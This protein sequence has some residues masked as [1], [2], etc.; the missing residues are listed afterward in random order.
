M[1]QLQAKIIRDLH[2][3]AS[4][5]P[6]EEIETRVEF[7]AEYAQRTG[8]RGFVLGISGGQDSSLAGRLCQLAI[9]RL[10]AEGTHAELLRRALRIPA[11]TAL[12]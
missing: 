9:E 4:I 11:L 12:I 10:A 6:R 7:L 8:G 2:V 1:R 3:T 5:N